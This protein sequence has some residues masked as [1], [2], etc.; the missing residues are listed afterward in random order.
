MPF[1]PFAVRSAG[2][3][4][5]RFSLDGR[6]TAA[7]GAVALVIHVMAGAAGGD[8]EADAEKQRTGSA[9]VPGM[10]AGPAAGP[11]TRDIVAGAYG[12]VTY[13]HPSVVAITKPGST[14]M[15]VKDFNWIGRPFDAPVYYGIRV[16]RWQPIGG[17]GSMVDFTHAKAI[18]VA[19]DE[20]AFAG[21]RDGK[22]VEPKAQIGKVFRHLEFSH[23]HNML[24]Y[25]ALFR[26]PSLGALSGPFRPYAGLGGGIT[27]PHTEI[28]F[29]DKNTRTYEY[30]FA[31]FVAQILCGIEINFGRTSMFVEYKFSYSPY[32]VPLSEEP[33]GFVLFTDLWRQFQA[34][35]TG[36]APSGGRLSTNLA[37]HH[38][39]VGV[40]SRIGAL[41]PRPAA[42]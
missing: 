42:P 26:W 32:E 34:W 5:L 8:I 15:T 21:T 7:L 20:A 23:G 31:G 13:T 36:E 28:G 30:Q 38:A 22:P 9:A 3:P 11:A 16:Q 39:N 6:F 27:L 29:A 24:T 17:F 37:T 12:G 25:N 10:A 33:R 40:L 35:A 14:D 2:L 19:S 18:A 4:R 1:A 41:S